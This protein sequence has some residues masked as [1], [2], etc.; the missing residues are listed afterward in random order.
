MKTLVANLAAITGKVFGIL[1]DRLRGL[2]G[3]FLLDHEIAQH[4][5]PGQ[6]RKRGGQSPAEDEVEAGDVELLLC[7]E[8]RRLA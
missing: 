3:Q 4:H 7:P 5:A 1:A 6:A 8:A 2:L